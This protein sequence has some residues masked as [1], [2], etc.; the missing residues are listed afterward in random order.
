MEDEKKI[1]LVRTL[2]LAL[3]LLMLGFGMG[4]L[5]QTLQTARQ[6]GTGNG[7][8]STQDELDLDAVTEKISLLNSE[9]EKYYLD[10]IDAEDL[11]EGIYK[12]LLAGLGDPY[13]EYYTGEEYQRI[14]ESSSGSYCGIGATL[15]QQ[16]DGSCAI[17]NTLSGSPA[18]EAG[19]LEGDII[20][21]VDDLE[22]TDMDLSQIVSYVKGEEG[23]QVKLTLIRDSK[24][25]EVTLIRR[26]IEVSTVSSEMKEDGVGYIALSEFDEVST[27][28]FREA[29]ES[30]QEQGMTSLIVDLRDNPGG[31]LTVVVDIL[32]MFLPEETV[33]YTE[34]K[35]GNRQDYTSTAQVV[36]DV[37]LVVLVNGNSASASEIFAGAIRDY[38]RG[39]LVGTTTFGKGIVQRILDLQDGSAIKL[40]IASYYTPNGDN[41]HGT[42]I[43]PDVEVELEEAADNGEDQQSDLQLEKA[44]E[45]L[46]Q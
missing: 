1:H 28:Q 31:M 32:D 42:G 14:L 2:A 22:V 18:E 45:L 23:T 38:K 6:N 20:Y 10:D 25:K 7:T 41:I 43:D 21:K 46:K 9:I 33:V 5:F 29:L 13:S 34:D 44:L 11:E 35:Y 19:L 36:T 30:L 4:T 26:T 3:L 39:T 8:Y 24:E 17:V 12:G 37:P 16:E 27:E 40:T 15:T